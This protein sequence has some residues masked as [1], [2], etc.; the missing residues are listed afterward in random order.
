MTVRSKEKETKPSLTEVLVHPSPLSEKG[1][2]LGIGFTA[3][4]SGYLLPAKQKA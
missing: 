4:G 3:W 2:A 1:N